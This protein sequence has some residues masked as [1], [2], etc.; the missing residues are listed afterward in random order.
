MPAKT[1][2]Q[3]R[4]MADD[5]KRL[6]SGRPRLTRMRE[7]G[8]KEFS[9]PN[10]NTMA[11][12]SSEYASVHKAVALI[13]VY[14][15]KQTAADY[16]TR[17]E[18]DALATPGIAQREAA[19]AKV[20]RPRQSAGQQ[21]EKVTEPLD[22]PDVQYNIEDFAPKTG[23]RQRIVDKIKA[24]P[25]SHVLY[26]FTQTQL[27]KAVVLIDAYLF[28]HGRMLPCG[29]HAEEGDALDKA[30]SMSGCSSSGGIN[31]NP[32]P[33]GVGYSGPSYQAQRSDGSG[34]VNTGASE[35]AYWSGTPEG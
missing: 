24:N 20:R 21:R 4:F 31:P 25:R 22:S 3:R 11:T 32:T 33:Q 1:E 29:H 23:H 27:N 13:D 14:F 7:E 28:K 15:V 6:R 17:R 35:A 30:C 16:L 8:L 26:P 12:K 9:E 2:K 10:A 19:E 34:S 5:L 18:V